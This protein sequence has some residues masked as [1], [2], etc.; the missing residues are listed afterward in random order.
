MCSKIT[1]SIYYHFRS[2]KKLTVYLQLLNLSGRQ[3]NLE[4]NHEKND[5]QIKNYL[6]DWIMHH[7]QILQSPI[8]N[9]FT[10]VKIDGHTE[11]QLVPKLLLQVSIRE[12]HN[13]LFSAKIYGGL[14]EVGAKDDNIIISDSTLSS[15][16][17]TQIKKTHKDTKLCV[18]VNIVYLPKLYIHH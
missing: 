5:E 15:L 17:P 16:L 1:V 9:D 6:S 4:K 14:K 2:E 12:L 7:P 18:V 11:P 8:V 3:L 10:K 13:K